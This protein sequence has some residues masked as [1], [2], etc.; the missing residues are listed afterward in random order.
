MYLPT[1][2]EFSRHLN[3]KFYALVAEQKYELEL[4]EV[5]GYV[6]QG[7]Q[8]TGLERF[9]LFF[10][11]S[12]FLPQQMYSLEHEQ[13]GALNVFLVPIAEN[14]NSFNYEAV[15]NYYKKSDQ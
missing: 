4:V 14:G 1:E 3:T 10:N 11:S 6:A 7:N 12:N 8:Q 15:F 2:E 5:K 9:S 13:M